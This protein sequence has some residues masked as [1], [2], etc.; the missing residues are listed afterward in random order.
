MNLEF[1]DNKVFLINK[2]TKYIYF[3]KCT[4]I[5]VVEI[6]AFPKDLRPGPKTMRA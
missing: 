5:K 1:M 6:V 3:V 4:Y 2:K